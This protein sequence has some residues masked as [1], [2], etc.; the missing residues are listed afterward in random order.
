[1]VS[2]AFMFFDAKKFEDV[3]GFDPNIFLFYEEMDICQRLKHKGYTTVFYPDS[4]FTHYQGKSSGSISMKNELTISYLY[5]IQ[6]NYA[7]WYYLTIRTV[8]L[9]KYG[10]KSIYKSKKYRTPFL[11]VLKGGNSLVYSIKP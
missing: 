6:K 3:G 11:I 10:V 1:M 4:S 2:G 9:I 5:V 7:Y 8:M